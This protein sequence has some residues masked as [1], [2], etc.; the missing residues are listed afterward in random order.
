MAKDFV[1]RV[2]SKTT[3][4]RWKSLSIELSDETASILKSPQTVRLARLVGQRAAI[5]LCSLFKH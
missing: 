5:A 4:D 3:L 1:T 2:G